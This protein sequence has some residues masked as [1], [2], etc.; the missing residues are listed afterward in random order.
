MIQKRILYG[1]LLV[2]MVLGVLPALS[3]AAPEQS[4][5]QD[6]TNLAI[7]P[8]F[9]G[10]TCR[11]GS[12]PPECLDNWTHD[13]HWPDE[14]VHDNIFTPQGWITWWRRGGN[15]GQPEVKTIPNVAPFTG[16]LPRIHSGH[17]ATLLFTFYRLQDTGLYQCVSAEAGSTVELTAYG[18]GWSCDD[19]EG[20]QMGYSCGDPYNQGFRVGIEPNGIADP[21]AASVIWN[22]K[23]YAPDHYKLIGPVSAQVGE[24]G[25]V[26]IFLRSTTKWQYKYADVYWDDVSLVQ[27]TAGVPPTNT[28]APVPQVTA[29]PPPTPLPTPTPRPD[30]SIVYIVQSGDTLSLISQKTGVPVDQIRTLNASSIGDGYIIHVGQELVL[31][32][33]N[34]T[35]EPTAPPTPSEPEAVAEASSEEGAGGAK[36]NGASICVLSFNDRNGDTFR[37]E[38]IE[39]LLPNAQITLANELG[40]TNQYTTDG[41]NEPYCFTG[42]AAG[43]YRVVQ[44][45]PTSYVVSGTA[46]QLVA[47]TDGATINLAFGNVRSEDA[48]DSTSPSDAGEGGDD[49]GM[50]SVFSTVAK[51]SG[52]LVLLLC[53]GVA[54]LFFLNRRRVM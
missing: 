32:L 2:I 24:S 40:T 47:V 9:E 37:D 51:V 28:P 33:P 10:I 11:P 50:R 35:P 41:F 29:G 5:T 6:Q 45:P 38:V 26:C 39:E 20:S 22:E 54:V 53:A 30:G 18:H 49:S 16:E 17:Y 8:G 3:L 4:P 14:P 1:I 42:L 13:V 48:A 36:A 52:V 34:K 15:Y 44:T 25:R 19:S 27:T 12:E 7:N 46:E 21:F 43:S 23:T 31:S